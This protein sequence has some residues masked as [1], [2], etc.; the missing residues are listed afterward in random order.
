[1][2]IAPAVPGMVAFVKLRWIREA[3]NALLPVA[4]IGG[5]FVGAR[6]LMLRAVPLSAAGASVTLDLTLEVLSQIAF[7]L[8][9]VTLLVHDPQHHLTAWMVG[10]I[11]AALGVLA[12]F[13]LAQRHGLFGVIERGLLRFSEKAGW[14]GLG[15]VRGLHE[16]IAALYRDPRRLAIASTHHFISWLLGGFEIM[17]ALHLVGHSI[18]FRDGLIIESL[19]QALRAVGFAVPGSLGVQEGGYV[20]VCGLVGI[21]PQAAIELSLLKRIREVALG[22]PGLIVWQAIEGHRLALRLKRA[23]RAAGSELAR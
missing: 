3:V 6:L 7:T 21:P 8:L 2:T 5:E 11:L 9:G 22:L 17:L 1:V 18:D 13:V 12:L 4:Q 10:G 15:D 16:A 20:L 19:G 23:R 14:S